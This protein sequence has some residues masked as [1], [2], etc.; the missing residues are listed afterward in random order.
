MVV[1]VV[2]AAVPRA[3]PKEKPPVVVVGALKTQKGNKLSQNNKQKS[4]K[5]SVSQ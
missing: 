3:V 1:L 5:P 4:L 2:G